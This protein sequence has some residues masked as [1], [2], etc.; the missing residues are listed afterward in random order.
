[1]S[2]TAILKT[3]LDLLFYSG[4]SQVLRGLCGGIGAIFMLHHIRPGAGNPH[5]FAP[6]SGLEVS[7]HF[8]D[9]VIQYAA[10]QGYDLVSLAEAVER[11]K[12]PGESSR[13]F[14]AFTIDDG[15]RDN[16]V[17]AWPVFRRRDCPFTIF[18]APA[19]AD[20]VC[21]LWWRGL[22]AVIAGEVAVAG[23]VAGKSFRYETRTD[24]QKQAA[25]RALY[26]PVRQMPEPEQR[27]WI[28]QFCMS[29]GVNLDAM[30]RSEAMTWSEL[31]DIAA[32][33]LCTIGAHTI[34]HYA[35]AKLSREEALQ[36]AVASRTRIEQEL[37]VTPR[38]FA[39]PYGDEGSAGPRDFEIIREAGFEAAVTTRKGVVFS[40]HRDHLTALPRV[41]LN[42]GFQ[43]LRYVD[44]LMNGSAFALW[45][46]FR[47]VKV[48]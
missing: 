48:A 7:P 47:R 32:D 1:M 14:A 4:A 41:S 2:K 6:N 5:G 16:F 25:Y 43:K 28:R 44:V 20:G 19:I 35:I 30:C 39:Y 46:G 24:N 3:S 36:E 10:G 31:R 22:E 29:H 12:S 45:N 34:N 13:P 26:W 8:L 38:F 27:A 23:E 18:V 17:H 42:G 15:Y 33:P 11:I 40:A 21:E 37:G 9:A